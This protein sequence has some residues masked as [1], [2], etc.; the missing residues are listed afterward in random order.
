MPLPKT[1]GT[2]WIVMLKIPHNRLKESQ[3]VKNGCLQIMVNLTL[4]SA[5]ITLLFIII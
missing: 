5:R 4:G 2:F 3:P 1:G